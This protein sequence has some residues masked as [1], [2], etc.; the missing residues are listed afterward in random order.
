MVQTAYGEMTIEELVKYTEMWKSMCEKHNQIRRKYNQS[1]AG[2]VKN[3]QKAKEYYERNK[4]TILEKRRTIREKQK[5]E[6]KMTE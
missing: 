5:E 3:R 4:E 6:Y 1:E 2:K